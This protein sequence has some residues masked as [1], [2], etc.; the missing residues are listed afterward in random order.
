[1]GWMKRIYVMCEDGTL[2]EE[3][4]KPYKKA[5]LEEK[6]S[7]YF[8]GRLITMSQAA[9]IQI[10]VDDAKHMFKHKEP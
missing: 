4:T 5:L 3:F 10:F 7:M 9:G 1:M 2:D 6:N 8:Q